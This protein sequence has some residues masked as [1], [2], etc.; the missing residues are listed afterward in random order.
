MNSSSKQE[1]L[2]NIPNKNS[3]F[4]LECTMNVTINTLLRLIVKKKN[5]NYF[6]YNFYIDEMQN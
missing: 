6:I 2:L 5:V 1:I 3:A 4:K